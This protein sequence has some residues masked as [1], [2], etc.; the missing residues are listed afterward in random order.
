MHC[1]ALHSTCF[2][3]LHPS[4]LASC[5]FCNASCPA[6]VASRYWGC[7][8]H[9]K[10]KPTH[11]LSMPSNQTGLIAM[12]CVGLGVHSEERARRTVGKVASAAFDSCMHA[13]RRSALK[14]P[15]YVGSR[16]APEACVCMQP[17]RHALHRRVRRSEPSPYAWLPFTSLPLVAAPPRY[18]PG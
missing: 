2:D 6:L 7:V 4:A 10:A 15:T 3:R 18:E 17:S 8:I 1:I 13:V 9:F 11:T 12:H 16:P 5:L 14:L